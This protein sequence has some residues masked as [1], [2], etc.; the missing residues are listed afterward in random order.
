A[1]RGFARSK[2]RGSVVLSAGL[3]TRLYSY[4]S[5]FDDFFPDEAGQLKKKIILKVSDLRSALVQGRFLARKG[6]WVS[7]YRVESG[8]N[9]GG[10]AFPTQGLLLGP[11]LEE[12]R[13]RR[14]QL[15]AQLFELFSR[16]LQQAGRTGG[17]V[18]PEMRLTVQGGIGTHEEHELLLRRFEVD[19][20]GWGTPFLLVPEAVNVDAE[21]LAKLAAARTGDVY[22]S[23]SSPLGILFWNLLN[24]GS[25]EA[26][27]ERIAR[28]APGSSCP[29]G[30]LVSDT[31]FTKV[32][33]CTASRAYQR[34]KLASLEKAGLAPA[35]LA[36]AR[37]SVVGKSCIC[38]DL[39]GCAPSSQAEKQAPTPAV[40]SGPNIVNFD[41]LVSLAEMVEHIYGERSVMQRQG[42]PH[43]FIRELSLYV[44]FLDREFQ[45]S[46]AGLACRIKSF[47]EFRVNLLA[48]IDY[49][50]G[51]AREGHLGGPGDF[52]VCLESL[53]AEVESL[54]PAEPI[55]V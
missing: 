19:G 40:C 52:Q 11:I 6:L 45:R 47:A 4:L 25:E 55:S 43:M 49:Y 3:N 8:L 54:I 41:R 1:L 30:Y 21:H 34:R 33:I 2:L 36:G 23:E 53:A 17:A 35:E 22:L 20:T 13:G 27:R 29:K 10:H 39:S 24:S 16:A 50:R 44:E 38:H 9:C 5:R 15:K 12:F 51:L 31:E 48:G 18:C 32:P 14:K 26:R 7:E 28:Q 46:K 37:E 42:R